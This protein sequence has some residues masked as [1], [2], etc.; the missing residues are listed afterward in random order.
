MVYGPE[1]KSTILERSTV[2]RAKAIGRWVKVTAQTAKL[3][4]VVL[5]SNHNILSHH[6][7]LVRFDLIAM[8]PVVPSRLPSEVPAESVVVRG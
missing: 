4:S 5:T 7:H 3:A 2:G 1:T 8:P 6:T